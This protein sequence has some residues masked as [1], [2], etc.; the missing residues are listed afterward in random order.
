[1]TAFFVVTET[2]ENYTNSQMELLQAETE[3]IEYGIDRDG[4]DFLDNL[5][6]TDYRI[7]VIKPDGT[8]IYDNSGQ[9]ISKMDNHLNRKEVIEALENEYGYST[10]LSS[11]FMERYVYTAAKLKSGDVVRVSNSYNS[12]I[13]TLRTLAEPMLLV[14]LVIIGLSFF[15][16][17]RLARNIV[18]PLYAI[19]M[20]NPD[21]VNCYSEI[22]P[23]LNKLVTQKS[24]I[25]SER[26]QLEQKKQEFE[27]ITENVNEGMILL[28]KELNILD[29]NKAAMNILEIDERFEGK[30]IKEI[31]DYERFASLFDEKSDASHSNIRLR[32]NNTSYEFEKSPVF[33]DD[34]VSGYVI[35]IFDESYKEAN[36]I[37][38]KEF[39]ANV[40]HELKTPLQAISGY[41]ELLRNNLVKEEN[42]QECFEKIYNESQRMNGL[43]GDIIK[44]SHL[45]EEEKVLNKESIDLNE[46][47]K[48]LIDTI[49]NENTQNIDIHYNG[50]KSMIYGN[51]ELIETIGFNLI[52]NAIKYNKENGEVFV[53][54]KNDDDNVYLIVKDTGIGIAKE[55]YDRI[56]ERFYR[57]NKARS[58]EVGGTGLGLSIVKHACILNDA[59]VK[60]DSELSKGSTFTVTF[61]K[62]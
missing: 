8:V 46:V 47:M 34:K 18:E 36:E 15:I 7:T 2:F 52:E 53:E 9:D 54:V 44:L 55:D 24:I 60:V 5:D 35:L 43:I 51:R 48:D 33:I 32:I 62:L 3:L 41:A 25:D 50:T 10:R 14:I 38:R 58:K 37:I 19:D 49:D 39:A 42:Q 28:N 16:A 13:H 26:E 40:S 59:T 57:V 6:K 11:T 17:Y 27:A 45:D 61:K 4:L 22:R 1:M 56:F 29:F 23:L 12:I 21:E 31:K 20:E 30:S